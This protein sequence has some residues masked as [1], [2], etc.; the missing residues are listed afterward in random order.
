M[1]DGQSKKEVEAL[2][3]ADTAVKHK[4]SLFTIL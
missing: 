2:R 3:E 1:G 4:L